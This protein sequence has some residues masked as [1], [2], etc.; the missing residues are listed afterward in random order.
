MK[1]ELPLKLMAIR[2]SLK[3]LVKAQALKRSSD[4]PRLMHSRSMC[5]L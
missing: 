2:L 5:F 4:V 1:R 3:V